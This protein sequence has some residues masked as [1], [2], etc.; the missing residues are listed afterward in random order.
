MVRSPHEA[1]NGYRHRSQ[2]ILDCVTPGV[3]HVERPI[4]PVSRSGDGIH[5]LALN[6]GDPVR[7]PGSSRL[8]LTVEIHVVAHN[9]GAASRPDWDV[10]QTGYIYALELRDRTEVV[11]YHWHPLGI[12]LVTNPHV[13]F[14][15]ASA[16]LDS[17]VRP[18]E[19]HKVHFPTGFVSLE[20]VIRLAI[21][22]FG[23]EPRRPDWD[24][25]L[26]QSR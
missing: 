4:R 12:G 9:S 24:A 2:R 23:V 26:A 5:V 20:D 7:M 13:H 10:S 6:S 3:L 16:R 19:L 14:G 15:P 25:I 17:A 8:S 21:V 1:I 11:A 22:E 18:G